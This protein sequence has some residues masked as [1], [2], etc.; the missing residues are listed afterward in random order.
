MQIVH[1]VVLRGAQF[2]AIQYQARIL[3]AHLDPYTFGALG[4]VLM[5]QVI[6][7]AAGTAK[8]VAAADGA[9]VGGEGID[10]GALLAPLCRIF[11]TKARVGAI[12]AARILQ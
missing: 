4:Q 5:M 2:L 3:V 12:Q 1:F 11:G 8:L 6:E 10:L 7:R 9:G